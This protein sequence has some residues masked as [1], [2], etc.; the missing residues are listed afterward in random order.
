M[1]VPPGHK[2][3]RMSYVGDVLLYCC[4]QHEGYTD[5]IQ[6]AEEAESIVYIRLRSSHSIER[7]KTIVCT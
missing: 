2:Y 6:G 1:H 5:C 7:N 4:A 3:T